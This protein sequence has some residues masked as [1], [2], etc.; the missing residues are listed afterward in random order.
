VLVE[1]A[2]ARTYV[3]EPHFE[4]VWLYL[5]E[6]G[7]RF[8]RPL[9]FRRDQRGRI[10]EIDA[11]FQR[12]RSPEAQERSGRELPEGKGQPQVVP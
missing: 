5:R 8:V 7:F 6:H 1:T 9:A 10:V 11:L 4:E 2:F 12:R 3:G